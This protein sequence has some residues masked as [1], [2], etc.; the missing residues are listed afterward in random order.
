MLIVIALAII[1]GL[2]LANGFGGDAGL[3]AAPSPGSSVSVSP[4]SSSP[5]PPTL[6]PDTVEPQD[7]SEVGFIA[8]NGTNETGLAAAADTKMVEDG[9]VSAGQPA[10]APQKG[11]AKT[12]VYYRQG[13][14]DEATAQN[15][16]NAEQI[17]RK[18]FGGAQ[19][20]PLSNDFDDIVPASATIVVVL[21]EDQVEP[22]LG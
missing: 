13:K 7:P 19:T 11:V 1:G 20:A 16:A 21:G 8:L 9:Y 15:Q 14:T 5:A 4:T 2:V 6:P 12:T 17:A 10:D 22:L 18:V 3:S